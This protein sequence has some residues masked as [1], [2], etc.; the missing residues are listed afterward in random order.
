MSAKNIKAIAQEIIAKT[1][2]IV[3]PNTVNL[4]DENGIIIA[5][6]DEKRIGTFHSGAYKAINEKK[7]ILIY[8]NEIDKFEGSK[9]GVNIPIIK[10]GKAVAVIGIFGNPDE[11]KQTAYLLSISTSL[12]L[13][14]A[15]YMQK[16]QRRTELRSN[17]SEIL[18]SKNNENVFLETIDALGISLKFP[19]QLVLFSFESK[20][21]QY[22]TTYQ[23]LR[24][25]KLINS[26]NDLLIEY[27]SHYLILKSDFEKSLTT[28][29]F[30]SALNQKNIAKIVFSPKIHQLNELSFAA[31]ISKSFMSIPHDRKYYNC[32]NY[33]DLAL[34]AFDINSRDLLTKYYENLIN[35]LD[36][37]HSYWIYQTIDAYINNDGRIQA[38]ANS[39]NIHKN[40]CIYR[41]NKILEICNLNNCNCFTVSYFFRAIMHIKKTDN[42]EIL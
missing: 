3:A 38:M 21:A 15:A 11:V 10:K 9:Q 41:V 16:E 20:K 17:L 27:P 30:I 35:E 5:S 29:D 25:N 28:N 24:D 7:E 13:D 2:S 42:S 6:S 37:M 34:L 36:N 8:P 40:T 12:F 1:A 19:L 26:N 31:M 32:T 4:M 33:D 14:Q 18:Y 23:F 39:L 22:N